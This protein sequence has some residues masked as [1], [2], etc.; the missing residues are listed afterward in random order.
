MTTQTLNLNMIPGGV[1]PVVHASQY[2]EQTNAII[3]KLYNGAT[4]FSVPGGA[5]VL[6]QGTKPDVTGF[7]YVASSFTGNTVILNVY[8]QMTAVA[9]DVMCE[10]RIA[11]SSQDVGSCN[12]ILRV[13]PSTLEDDVISETDLPLI[14]QA[15]EIAATISEYVET[16]A[17]E[18]AAAQ[19]YAAA[20]SDSAD[21]AAID[22]ANVAAQYDALEELKSDTNAA[23][24]RAE[25]AADAISNISATATTLSAGS[26]ATASYNSSTNV[27]TFGIPTGA[28]GASGVTTPLAGF[29]TMWVDPDTGNL[30]AASET[31]L[32]DFFYYDSETGNLYYLTE[33]GTSE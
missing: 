2:D 17:A 1:L 14:Q 28:T 26:S 6:C 7:S 21:E 20:A 13:E 15:A 25:D 19:G 4:A 27:F 9:G 16:V 32:S 3:F 8:K 33:D 29:F 5:S 23:A 30:Y 18:A 10:L 11:T 22:A 12:F 31:D 24:E